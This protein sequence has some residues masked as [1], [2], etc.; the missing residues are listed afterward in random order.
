MRILYVR[1]MSLHNEFINNAQ[2]DYYTIARHFVIKFGV[3]VDRMM[4]GPVVNLTSSCMLRGK[5]V[6]VELRDAAKQ[7]V[8]HLPACRDIFA[9]LGVRYAEPPTGD[10]R[11]Q[12]PQPVNM[13][14]GIRDATEFGM[15]VQGLK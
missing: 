6:K 3:F 12:P 15:Y 11:F 4:A 14:S 2:V 1:D 9:F 7:T 10:K 13:W 8:S 5:R